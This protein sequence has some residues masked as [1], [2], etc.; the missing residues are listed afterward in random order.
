M[1]KVLGYDSFII[2]TYRQSSVAWMFKSGIYQWASFKVRRWESDPANQ[3]T[4]DRM[5]E[6]AR[7]NLAISEDIPDAEKEQRYR[8]A[9]HRYR[10]YWQALQS[11][12]ISR[13]G[14]GLTAM[15]LD[16]PQHHLSQEA[17]LHLTSLGE[18]QLTQPW[19][20]P[21]ALLDNGA[22]KLVPIVL[23]AKWLARVDCESVELPGL[24]PLS[25]F[26]SIQVARERVA[27]F[28]AAV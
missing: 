16:G 10:V 25:D 5:L 15:Y 21:G 18:Q 20:G 22:G 9:A 19:Q 2:N 3:P 23:T 4:V 11:S 7:R 27:A 6:F 12:G 26:A 1:S 13:L 14:K 24:V 8:A 28:A 17:A